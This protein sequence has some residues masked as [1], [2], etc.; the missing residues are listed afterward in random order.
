MQGYP[1]GFRLWWEVI[2]P[3]GDAKLT[4]RLVKKSVLGLDDSYQAGPFALGPTFYPATAWRPGDT[5]QQDVTLILPEDLPGGTYHLQVQV[6]TPDGSPQ[7]VNGSRDALTLWERWQRHVT[8]QGEWGDLFIVQ[9][10]VKARD[11][12]P[13][14][15]R[16]RADA[17][18]GEILR[19]RGYRLSQSTLHPG[20]S[21]D[22]TVYW[23][24][25][26]RPDRIYAVFNHLRSSDATMIWQ[27]DSWPQ[28]GIYTTDHWLK[29][30]V[31]EEHY[32][33]TLPQDTPPGEYPLYVGVYDAA[34][35]DRLPATDA[36]GE[37]Y[38]NDQVPLLT[39]EVVTP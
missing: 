21:A 24:A 22:L 39:L 12:R 10:E 36:Q 30:E 27:Q 4:V 11:Y 23:Q 25:L 6:L 1:L 8:L 28:A 32:T 33:L 3:P 14:L 7:P 37:R 29:G 2:T 13:P 18:F 34:T 19:L 9:V 16:Q 35:G 38:L 5:V 31:V 26:Q 15:R 20:A 17:R